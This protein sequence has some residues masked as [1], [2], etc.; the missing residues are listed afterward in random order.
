MRVLLVRVVAATGLSFAACMALGY[1]LSGPMPQAG[2]PP[3]QLVA[4]LHA[5]GS[6]QEWSWFFA[7]GP[8]LL[9]GP[10]FLG[11]L[12]AR[13][14]AVNPPGRALTAA[15]FASGLLAGA[16]LASAS[17]LWGLFVYLG[18]QITSPSLVLVL[19]EARHFA[20]GSVSF[21][22]AGA[23]GAFSLA[24]RGSRGWRS[25]AAVGV[26]AAGL[27]LANGIYD[28]VVDGV[29][30]LLGPASFVALLAWIVTVSLTSARDSSSQHLLHRTMRVAPSPT[31]SLYGRADGNQVDVVGV[32]QDPEL[33]GS[34]SML[35]SHRPDSCDRPPNPRRAVLIRRRRSEP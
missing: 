1:A 14:W 7:S 16:L 31:V 11:A 23:V 8:A 13:L 32:V 22:A 5:H 9:F 17:V 12:A 30:G 15:G 10:W 4:L 28:F 21:P 3:A 18:T 20:E 19:A 2:T 33:D 27:Q 34:N 24:A 35:A 6:T 26:V 29:T 25:V